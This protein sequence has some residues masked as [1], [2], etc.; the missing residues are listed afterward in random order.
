MLISDEPAFDQFCSFYLRQ[1]VNRA[2]H[3][4]HL[5]GATAGL[6]SLAVAF[7]SRPNWL[8]SITLNGIPVLMQ[9][10]QLGV[11]YKTDWSR[12][13]K[14]MQAIAKGTNEKTG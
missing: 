7:V 1:H 4:L 12:K 8:I 3:K 13:H 14:I 11:L 5:F 9:M 10:R 6:I 2:N